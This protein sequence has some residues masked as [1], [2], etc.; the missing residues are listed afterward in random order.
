MTQTAPRILCVNPG[1]TSTKVA[2]FAGGTELFSEDMDHDKATLAA[3]GGVQG[4][5][6]LR[7]EAVAQAVARHL[8]EA[9]FDAVAGAAGCSGPCL[10]AFMP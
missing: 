2:A 5:L 3:C 6:S 1:S 9:S 7:R 10:E 8:G 4:Q